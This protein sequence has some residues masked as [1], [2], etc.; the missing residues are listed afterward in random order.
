M[1]NFGTGTC[2]VTNSGSSLRHYLNPNINAENEW[3]PYNYKNIVNNFDQ[4]KET[5]VVMVK[6]DE[7]ESFPVPE[8]MYD[9]T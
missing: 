2:K 5:I 6:K 7:E 1:T 9:L 8:L 3:S 4:I